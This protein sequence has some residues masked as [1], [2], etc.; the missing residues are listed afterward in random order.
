M[1]RP[2]AFLLLLLLAVSVSGCIIVPE[3][4]GRGGW[5]HRY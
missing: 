3:H 1:P 2:V 4:D 5:H